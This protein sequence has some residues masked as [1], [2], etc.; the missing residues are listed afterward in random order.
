MQTSVVKDWKGLGWSRNVFAWGFK[1]GPQSESWMSFLDSSNL[2]TESVLCFLEF[3]SSKTWNASSAWDYGL[4]LLSDCGIPL[5]SDCFKNTTTKPSSR[6]SF[7]KASHSSSV[8]ARVFLSMPEKKSFFC[9]SH[10]A[11]VPVVQTP[12]LLKHAIN[13]TLRQ[14]SNKMYL[15]S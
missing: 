12:S 6:D 15:N 3:I 5:L 4:P 8:L 7:F 11:H 2:S 1:T 10:K 9:E 14:S 13:V